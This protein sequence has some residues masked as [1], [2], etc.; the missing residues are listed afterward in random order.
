MSFTIVIKFSREKCFIPFFD[1]FNKLKFE[2]K[3]CHLILINNTFDSLISEGLLSNFTKNSVSYKSICLIQT[4][5]PRFDR[6]DKGWYDNVPHPFNTWTA[7]YSFQMLKLIRDLVQDDIHIQL[8]D[9]SLPHPDA[10]THLL[11]IMKENKDCACATTPLANRDVFLK[12][13]CMN[14]YSMIEKKDNFIT[15]RISCDPKLSGVHEIAATGYHCVAFRKN[16]FKRA[17]QHVE[18]LPC[19]IMKSGSDIYL[20]SFLYEKGNKILLDYDC[21]GV[22][23]DTKRTYEKKDC[24]IW[25]VIWNDARQKN[26]VLIGEK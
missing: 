3:D 2:K 10:I 23:I 24:I 22:H 4:N 18:D 5:N 16:P 12:T 20:T 25:D 9:D 8:E 7:Y 1:A 26:N 14:S 15:R 11:K 21:W 13:L 19:K 6:G 17:V